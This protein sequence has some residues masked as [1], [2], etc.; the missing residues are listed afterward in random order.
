MHSADRAPLPDGGGHLHSRT[1]PRV[2]TRGDIS[3]L[4]ATAAA[5]RALAA[6]P[7]DQVADTLAEG[8]VGLASGAAV[9]GAGETYG[10]IVAHAGAALD[11]AAVRAAAA[12][13]L[14]PDP[15][16][17]A[18]P[19]SAGGR[20]LG[21]LVVSEPRER[22]ALD[23]LAG[24]GGLALAAA[25]R[26]RSEREVETRVAA[27]V[28]DLKQPVTV[29]D[30]VIRT[31]EARGSDVA[32]HDAAALLAAA[33][34]RSAELIDLI[35]RVL[36]T[37]RRGQDQLGAFTDVPLEALVEAATVGLGQLRPL[38]VGELP[39]ACLHVDATAARVTLQT[40]LDNAVRH[41]PA[42][43]TVRIAGRATADNAVIVVRNDRSDTPSHPAG[44]GFGLS[45][46]YRLAAA[47]GGRLS[48]RTEHREV[49]AQLT[50]PLA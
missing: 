31:L 39:D 50:L 35:E 14:A 49:V 43:S 27:L 15:G 5:A 1:D 37:T 38:E 19:L 40:L 32:P 9:V 22:A 42:G 28:H 7:A 20:A 16:L 45:I 10:E 6:A 26:E 29:L 18:L 30:G 3:V 34:R 17:L 25:E 33:G 44:T 12:N 41:S 8:A 36:Q 47:L 4:A 46:A 11:P 48:Y 23:I 24:Q 13:P 21:T 2:G